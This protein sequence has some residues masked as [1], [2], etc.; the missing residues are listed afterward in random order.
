M[1][2]KGDVRA[3]VNS[4]PH[5]SLEH[6]IPEGGLNLCSEVTLIESKGRPEFNSKEDHRP[7]RKTQNY[8]T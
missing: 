8:K 4:Q 3:L 2:R 6:S 7:K 5:R 1:N